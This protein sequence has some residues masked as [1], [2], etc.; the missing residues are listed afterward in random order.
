MGRV[1][2]H[3]G[4]GA[5]EIRFPFDRGLVERIK[6]LPHRRWNASGR[7]WS[8]PD[9][10]V[11]SL[12]DLL[13]EQSF[14]FD[15]ATQSLYRANGGKGTLQAAEPPGPRSGAAAGQRGLFDAWPSPGPAG[16]VSGGSTAPPSAAPADVA[17]PPE[18]TESA[19]VDHVSVRQ[20]NEQVQR[21]LTRAF[22]ETIWLVG[23]VRGFDKNAHKRHVG[24]HLVEVSEDGRVDAEVSATLFQRTRESV[25][26]KLA[27]AG[28][29][30]RL[31]D[32][33]QVRLAVR[34]ELYVPW[35]SYRVIVEDLD[36][37]FTLGEAARRR[38]EILRRLESEGLT[39]RNRSLAIPEMPLRV[40][41]I[42][43]LGSDAYNDVLRTLQES[44][45]AFE[46]TAHGARVQGRNTEPTVLNALDWFAA[47][48]DAFDVVLLCRGGGSRT[49]LG[50]FDSE[51]LGRAV[52]DFP[53]PIVAG[54]GHEQDHCVVDAMAHRAKTPTAAA[55]RLVERVDAG[56]ERLH[57]GLAAILEQSSARLVR[58]S[59]RTRERGRRAAAGARLAVERSSR[60][61]DERRERIARSSRLAIARGRE[62]LIRCTSLLPERVGIRLQRAEYGNQEAMRRVEAGSRRIIE[63]AGRRLEEARRRLPQ[64]GRRLVAAED[65]RLRARERRLEAL[66]PQ[67]VLDRGFALLTDETDSAITDAAAVPRGT[68][69]LARLRRGRLA[70][71]ADGTVDVAPPDLPPTPEE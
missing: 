53:R 43:S 70:L 4:Q 15:E 59:E 11:V 21:V 9:V 41:L 51:A 3:D 2:T 46:V 19:A 40:G 42:T 71:I 49:D 56:L 10:D 60:R 63:E 34:I 26:A 33:I 47:R 5:L 52:A 28:A 58:E 30:F 69:L 18:T 68:R 50:W 64:A 23:E 66:H 13:I 8:V 24:F 7:F 44:G 48:A 55:A 62:R 45:Y 31:E 37:D 57:L 25:E 38:E 54:I 16:N 27:R 6:S 22:P 1:V 35:G 61:L 39:E 36:V 29:P 17:A 12:V 20:L 65:E 67:R 32:E 14:E